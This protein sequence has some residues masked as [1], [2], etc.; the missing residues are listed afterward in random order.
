MYQPESCS[1]TVRSE[2]K[3]YFHSWY[4]KTKYSPL[5]KPDVDTSP[6]TPEWLFDS[7]DTVPKYVGCCL[8]PPEKRISK[9]FLLFMFCARA[10]HWCGNSPCIA[11]SS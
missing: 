7:P 5:R 4:S 10:E 2:L 1:I 8:T 3:I 11:V 9:N 6:D